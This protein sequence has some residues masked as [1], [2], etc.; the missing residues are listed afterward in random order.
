MTS[1][2]LEGLY[3][4]T[5]AE[6]KRYDASF[7]KLCYREDGSKG[8]SAE[9]VDATKAVTVLSKSGLPPDT[10]REIWTLADVDK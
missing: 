6:R 2:P 1:F 5:E 3:D 4:M 8:H 7:G 10:L 9:V